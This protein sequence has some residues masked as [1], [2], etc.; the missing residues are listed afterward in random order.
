MNCANSILNTLVQVDMAETVIENYDNFIMNQDIID[1][2]NM[3]LV[4]VVS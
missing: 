3:A 2:Y 4:P 1:N